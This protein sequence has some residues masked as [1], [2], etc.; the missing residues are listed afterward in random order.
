MSRFL[1]EMTVSAEVKRE[2]FVL[3]H[4]Q[5]C[6][7]QSLAQYWT[8]WEQRQ[9]KINDTHNFIMIFIDY[10]IIVLPTDS[11]FP[12]ILLVKQNIKLEWPK[13][14]GKITCLTWVYLSLN[15]RAIFDPEKERIQAMLLSAN[16]VICDQGL[17]A[18]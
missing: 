5:F 9:I 3:F 16:K 13:L 6:Q 7:P 17:E 12:A 18:C 15:H 11:L 8:R 2:S 1:W 14:G 4:L 10:I